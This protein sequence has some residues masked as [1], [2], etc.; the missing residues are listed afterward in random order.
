MQQ[1]QNAK[2]K[3]SS[4]GGFNE[5]FK[6]ARHDEFQREYRRNYAAEYDRR[7][8]EL[9]HRRKLPPRYVLSHGGSFI[10]HFFN[11]RAELSAWLS[12]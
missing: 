7:M 9:G 2:S 10:V 5:S 1:L 4:V 11:A 12:V 8:D 3:T 6:R